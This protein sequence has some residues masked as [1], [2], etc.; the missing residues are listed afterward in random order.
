MFKKAENIS[1]ILESYL[2]REENIY[3]EIIYVL[4]KYLI[5]KCKIGRNYKKKINNMQS[6]SNI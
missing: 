6:L 4:L 3:N 5:F 2:F 1:Q